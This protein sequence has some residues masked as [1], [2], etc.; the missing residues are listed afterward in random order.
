MPRA[1]AVALNRFVL[2]A[3]RHFAQIGERHVF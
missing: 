2:V 3:F 1:L